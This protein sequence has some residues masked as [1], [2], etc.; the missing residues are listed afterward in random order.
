MES[1][2]EASMK[3]EFAESFE[4]LFD[5]IYQGDAEAI[6]LSV[7]LLNVIHAWD[8]IVDG[9]SVSVDRINAAFA[10]AMFELSSSWLWDPGAIAVARVQYAKWRASNMIEQDE[11]ATP[12][13]KAVA[14]VYRAGFFDLFYYFAYKLYGME[15]VES[16][17]PIIARCY[18]EPVDTYQLEFWR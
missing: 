8:D 12:Q 1:R 3:P 18:G 2:L 17:S 9:D 15:W 16:I 5:F 11:D 6:R 13:N 7:E 14:Y 4:H 10:G